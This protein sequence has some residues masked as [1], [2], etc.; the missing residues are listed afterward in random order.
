MRAG[1]LF[2]FGSWHPLDRYVAPARRNAALWLIPLAAILAAIVY[3]A[4][5][6]A[7]VLAVGLVSGF[8]TL[9]GAPFTDLTTPAGMLGFLLTFGGA[10]LG[11]A[12]AVRILHGR[13]A[14]TLL[15]PDWVPGWSPGVSEGQRPMGRDAWRTALA[16]ACTH[17]PLVAI[18]GFAGD[19]VANRSLLAWLLLLPFAVPAVLIQTLGE[20]VVFR[21]YLLQQLGARFRSPLAWMV[22]PAIGFGA[23]HLANGAGAGML[24]IWA[25][26]F[27]LIAA[28]LTARTGTLAAAWAFH[29]ANNASVMLI[30]GDEQMP[31]L[32][33]WTISGSAEAAASMTV[34]TLMVQIGLLALSWLAVRIALRV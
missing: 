30:A 6:C 12:L 2:P 7:Q 18:S 19:L 28:D 9:M 21:G 25:F 4:W 26:A 27:G 8:G 10:F 34:G 33:L 3:L 14:R 22:L 1:S 5:V 15:A 11:V 31:G 29:A 24:S 23:L 17:L 20:E 32:T 16:V 13:A